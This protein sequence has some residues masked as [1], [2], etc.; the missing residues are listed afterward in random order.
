MTA[1]P[2]E[3]EPPRAGIDTDPG[4]N[5]ETTDTNGRSQED[6]VRRDPPAATPRWCHQP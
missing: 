5:T 6:D 3:T 4:N 2:H 1:D